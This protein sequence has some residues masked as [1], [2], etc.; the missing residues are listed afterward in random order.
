MSTYTTGDKD[1]LC[2]DKVPSLYTCHL[3]RVAMDGNLAHS[4]IILN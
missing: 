1:G 2:V 3:E 4:C